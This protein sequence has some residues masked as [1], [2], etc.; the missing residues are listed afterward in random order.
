MTVFAFT[1]A[2][3]EHICQSNVRLGFLSH[4]YHLLPL[5]V[6]FLLSSVVINCWSN[7]Q[8]KLR[9]VRNELWPQGTNFGHQVRATK[10]RAL[11]TK[12]RALATKYEL[13]GT[14]F[15]RQVWLQHLP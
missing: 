8:K 13:Q 5:V 10:V 14:S 9:K 3:I 6:A 11:A 15:G 1:L 4:I 2:Q 12:V 7:E